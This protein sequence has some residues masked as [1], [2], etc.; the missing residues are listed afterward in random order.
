MSIHILKED[1][2]VFHDG[3]TVESVREIKDINVKSEGKRFQLYN[4]DKLIASLVV[5]NRFYLESF[6]SKTI[7]FY[8]AK[9]AHKTI[10]FEIYCDEQGIQQLYKEN[11]KFNTG[12]Y[13]KTPLECD[14]A[15]E[16]RDSVIDNTKTNSPTDLRGFINLFILFSVLNYGRLIIEHTFKFK[17]MFS[18]NVR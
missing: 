12:I 2:F 13:H 18:T 1:L 7:A 17:S 10:I 16:V 8:R 9:G 3:N 4:K 14:Y 15:T 6:D 5:K 11:K